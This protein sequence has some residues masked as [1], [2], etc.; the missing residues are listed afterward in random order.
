MNFYFSKSANNPSV[1]PAKVKEEPREE[2][3]KKKAKRPSD[4]SHR[5]PTKA[6]AGAGRD[7]RA[8]L[9][10]K[11]RVEKRKLEGAIDTRK[12]ERAAAEV[13]RRRKAK[14]KGP[15]VG[16]GPMILLSRISPCLFCSQYK[17]L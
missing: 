7:T 3:G 8:M 4:R 12:K 13:T 5:A 17:Q 16:Q 1:A 10:E 9:A 6:K 11:L 15:Q 14:Q 2:G